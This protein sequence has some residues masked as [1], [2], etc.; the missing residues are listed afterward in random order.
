MHVGDYGHM[1]VS[2][3]A[4]GSWNF[5]GTLTVHHPGLTVL[6]AHDLLRHHGL[7]AVLVRL[8]DL[9]LEVDDGLR[10]VQALRAAVRAVHDAVA[11]V[12]LHRVVH[13]RQ[14]LLRVLVARVGDP[15]V[16][17][18]EHGGAEVELGVPPVGG[19]GGHAAG[20]E[21]AL[22]HAVELGAVVDGL[23]VLGLALRLRL[24]ALQPGL[25]GLVLV[26]EVGEVGHEV[27]HDVGV[28][29]GLDFD[30]LRVL[31]DVA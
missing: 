18:H 6:V 1:H 25:D 11:A 20:A 8:G 24:L 27:L 2:D 29:Q 14:P 17:L 23:V 3:C 19:A 21:D 13:P 5:C 7:P 9:R 26:V 15:P 22:V 10:R 31:L 30:G 12:E 28:G 16:R 4:Q